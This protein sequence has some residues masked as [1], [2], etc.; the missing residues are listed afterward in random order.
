[1]TPEEEL[2]TLIVLKMEL[3]HTYDGTACKTCGVVQGTPHKGWNRYYCKHLTDKIDR[4]FKESSEEITM[5]FLK[6]KLGGLL[7]D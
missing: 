4:A 7:G 3:H 5:K 1:M 6:N 2:N